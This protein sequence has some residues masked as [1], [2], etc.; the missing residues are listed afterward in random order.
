[1][2][3]EQQVQQLIDMLQRGIEKA[4][5]KLGV[6]IPHL[7]GVLIKQQYVEA[8]QALVVGAIIFVT[9]MW[10]GKFFKN[11]DAIARKESNYYAGEYIF[12]SVASR[13]VVAIALIISMSVAVGRFINPDFYAIQDIA[14]FVTGHDGN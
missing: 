10:L 3:T 12:F 2:I 4:S 13:I 8:V 9:G 14:N 5:E 11:R 7:W 6:A 1:M